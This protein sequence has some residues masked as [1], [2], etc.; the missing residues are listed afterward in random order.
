MPIPSDPRARTEPLEIIGLLRSQIVFKWADGH[1]TTI[2]ARD[3]RLRC[4]CA[5]CIEESTG[6]PLLNAESVSP[7]IRAKGIELVGQ[8][9][10]SIEWTEASCANIYSFRDIRALCSCAACATATSPSGPVPSRA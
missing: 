10:I 4:R 3:L 8:Y 5:Q 2:S 7:R 1:E 9:G 6:R